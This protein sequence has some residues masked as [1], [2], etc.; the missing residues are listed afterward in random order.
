[1][2]RSGAPLIEHLERVAEE[3]PPEARALAYLHDAL[4]RGERAAEELRELG[5]SDEELT[6]ISLLTRGQGDPYKTYVMRIARARGRSGSLART[7]KRADLED[8]LHQRRSAAPAPDYG[9][10]LDQ[11]AAATAPEP[12]RAARRPDGRT[13]RDRSGGARGPARRAA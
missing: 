5:L 8:H 13:R 6:V 2:T 4:E 12:V 7:I 10:A 1:M 11:I 9:W 3:V